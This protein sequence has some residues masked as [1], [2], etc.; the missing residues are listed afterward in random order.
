MRELISPGLSYPSSSFFL[1]R[2]FKS[3][4]KTIVK[5]NETAYSA[6]IIILAVSVLLKLLLALFYKKIGKRSIRFLEAAA[7]DSIS[8]V[9]SSGVVIIGAVIEN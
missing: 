9:L 6:L 2:A 3:S 8:D 4:V 5:P 7:T 1:N